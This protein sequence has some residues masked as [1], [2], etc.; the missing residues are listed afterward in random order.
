MGRTMIDEV[1][2]Y[3]SR[4]YNRRQK[5]P[6]CQNVCQGSCEC[7]LNAIHFC[8][9]YRPYNCTNIANYYT[10]KYS[11]KY[12]SEIDILL[13]KLKSLKSYDSF[14]VL[15]IGCGPCTDLMGLYRYIKC[16]NI[17]R[18]LTYMGFD[19][20]PIWKSIHLFIISLFE[21]NYSVKI[22]F[23][24]SDACISI[25]RL[26]LSKI[27][28]RPNIL[29]LQYVLSDMNKSGVSIK[30]FINNLIEKIIPYMPIYSYVIINDINH[31]ETRKWFEYFERIFCKNYTSWKYKGYFKSNTKKSYSYGTQH[32]T[33]KLTCNPPSE[34]TKFN[35]WLFCSSAHMVLKKRSE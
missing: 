1:L 12:S 20:N 27:T 7:C 4:N 33:N 2:K 15:S 35:P 14:N 25:P 22:R 29:I 3:C 11:C 10:C 23:S 9:I 8:K 6:D 17:D 18:E 13:S 31:M 26:D 21:S 16:E 32:D 19:M 28:W 30:D 5:C 24:Y 34:I